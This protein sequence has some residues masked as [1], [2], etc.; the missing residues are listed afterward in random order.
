VSNKSKLVLFAIVTLT[1]L[2]IGSVVGSIVL[3]QTS[4]PGGIT[5]NNGNNAAQVAQSETT[6]QT[7]V[8]IVDGVDTF[9]NIPAAYGD[10]TRSQ[11]FS[12]NMSETS[13]ST[14]A[15]A[16]ATIDLDSLKLVNN[17]W[18]AS[19]DENL[20]CAVYHN[21]SKNFGWSWNRQDPKTKPGIDGV[22]PIYP[23]LRI[24][25]NPWE[26]SNSAYFPIRMSAVET[27]TFQVAYDYPAVPTGA[28][29]LAYDMFFMDT[30]KSSPHPEIK[31]EVMIWLQGTIEQPQETYKGDYTDGRNTY[32]LFSHV[33][34]SGRLYYAFVMKGKPQFQARHT[35][36]VKK[37][38]DNLDLNP[39][40]Y[41]PG[42]EFGSEVVNGSGKIEINKFSLNVNNS[43]IEQ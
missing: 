33:M 29:D 35:V 24:G 13:T 21:Q 16:G 20:T 28:F 19:A 41:I 34:S 5:V 8:S 4:S 22:L 12:G 40:W 18:G 26:Q 30:N 10:Q 42:V 27:L 1:V 15:R 38:L 23:G 9:S 14:T 3:A 31:A 36:D 17:Q 11:G 7:P 39:N 6:A 37:L 32:E 25:G 43:V 2:V